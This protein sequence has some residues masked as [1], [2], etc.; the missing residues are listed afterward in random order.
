MRIDPGIPIWQ[1]TVADLLE[2]LKEAQ[3][4]QPV[5]QQPQ[6]KYVYGLAGI[7]KLFGCSRTTASEIKKSGVIDGAITQVG[8][9]IVV[10][11]DLALQLA[12]NRQKRNK[13][14]QL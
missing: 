13:S 6:K 8:R 11:M 5:M 3:Q 10:D 7:A 9:T 4:P 1:L 12:K 2:I 14:P